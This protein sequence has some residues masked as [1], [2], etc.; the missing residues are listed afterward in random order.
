MAAAGG[1]AQGGAIC[2]Q[3]E[4]SFADARQRSALEG[5]EDV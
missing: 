2:S 5:V 4:G 1:A 3:K